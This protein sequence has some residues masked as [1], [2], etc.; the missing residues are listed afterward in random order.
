M[1]V[2][3]ASPKSSTL[4]SLEPLPTAPVPTVPT[5]RVY[6]SGLSKEG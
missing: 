5:H 4:W 3:G 1:W 6:Y 2:G